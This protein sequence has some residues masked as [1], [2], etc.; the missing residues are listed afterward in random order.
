MP[1]H[2]LNCSDHENSVFISQNNQS[3]QTHSHVSES[4]EINQKFEFSS[5]FLQ[6]H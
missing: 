6:T 3:I 4:Y 5:F 1:L 2:L